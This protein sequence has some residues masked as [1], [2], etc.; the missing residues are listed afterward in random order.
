MFFLGLFNYAVSSVQVIWHQTDGFVGMSNVKG[1]N[2]GLLKANILKCS[3]RNQLIT[4]N[5]SQISLVA[6]I[7]I[8]LH[9]FNS[10]PSD[11]LSFETFTGYNYTLWLNPHLTVVM[12][13]HDMNFLMACMRL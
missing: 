4:D 13:Q 10:L 6:I 2:C 1:S 11:C 9:G 3:Y 8:T 7:Q 12:Q 5:I